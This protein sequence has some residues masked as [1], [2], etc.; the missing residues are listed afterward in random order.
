MFTIYLQQT[1]LDNAIVGSLYIIIFFLRP[2]RTVIYSLNVAKEFTKNLLFLKV[3]KKVG[4]LYIE[5]TG[6]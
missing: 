5:N 3:I 4:N 1:L 6:N 2:R